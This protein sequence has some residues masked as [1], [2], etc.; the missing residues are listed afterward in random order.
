[1]IDSVFMA[2]N[3]PATRRKGNGAAGFSNP[4]KIRAGKFQGLETPVRSSSAT[5]YGRARRGIFYSFIPNSFG[6][7]AS[8]RRFNRERA[9]KQQEIYSISVALLGIFCG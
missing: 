6:M 3:L 1:M 5:W 8:G 9:K 4:W 7:M 2:G